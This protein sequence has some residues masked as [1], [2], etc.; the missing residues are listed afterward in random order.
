MG[1]G[2]A[3]LENVMAQ[4]GIGDSNGEG[5]HIIELCILVNQSIMNT[6]YEFIRKTTGLL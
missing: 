4:F 3:G 2:K 5:K 1:I 6:F